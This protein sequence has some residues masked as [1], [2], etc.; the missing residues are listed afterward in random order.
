VANAFVVVSA[1]WRNAYVVSADGAE[2]RSV[3]LPGIMQEGI[4][5]L[6]DG[7]FIIVQDTGGLLRWKPPS[8]PF[9]AQQDHAGTSRAKD[10]QDQSH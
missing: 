6:P 7:S 10:T 8:D 2:L 1:L 4:A 9:R 5:R 3:R